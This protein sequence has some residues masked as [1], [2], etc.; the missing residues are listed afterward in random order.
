FV[1]ALVVPSG[2]AEFIT[3]PGELRHIIGEH[4]ETLFTLAQLRVEPQLFDRVPTPLGNGFEQ[5][6][7]SRLPAGRFVRVDPERPAP[8]PLAHQRHGDV[9]SLAARPIARFVDGRRARVFTRIN[10]DDGAPAGDLGSGG[11]AVVGKAVH[12][13]DRFRVPAVIAAD[14]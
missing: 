9:G 11:G 7:L 6:N 12:A 5:R 13:R 10:I 2:V 1:P 3:G 4:A 8:A 14:Q